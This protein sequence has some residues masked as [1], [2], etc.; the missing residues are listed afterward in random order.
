M[1]AQEIARRPVQLG[2][3][4]TAGDPVYDA[5]ADE[6][7][8]SSAVAARHADYGDGLVDVLPLA[9]AVAHA[10]GEM[11][12]IILGAH[13]GRGDPVAVARPSPDEPIEPARKQ[14]SRCS[15]FA[16]IERQA[17]T[18]P[19][20]EPAGR[21]DPKPP[22]T[23]LPFY[24]KSFG[25]LAGVAIP[26]ASSTATAWAFRRANQLD[27]QREWSHEWPAPSVP[28]GSSTCPSASSA[29][30]H[31][32]QRSGDNQT[33]LR[34]SH[35]TTQQSKARASAWAHGRPPSG[36]RRCRPARRRKPASPLPS[37]RPDR[38]GVARRCRACDATADRGRCRAE[39]RTRPAPDRRHR[40]R[41]ARRRREPP[42]WL[43]RRSQPGAPA[44]RTSFSS[45]R[46][47]RVICVHTVRTVPSNGFQ[48]V[49]ADG[50]GR[51]CTGT[52]RIIGYRPH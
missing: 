9:A 11:Q 40:S 44:G 35:S 13:I 33:G 32:R 45:A 29:F 34:L 48:W 8:S 12:P 43:R 23:R 26:I 38:D 15:R 30:P 47:P 46:L 31:P 10:V 37:S 36:T 4:P 28:K 5:G 1:P 18:L 24:S 52:V 25:N 22:I 41:D 7:G 49:G 2:D 27:Q 14:P 19:R 21:P 50:W 51:V 42:R 16:S 3:A 20:P 17:S 39:P 6:I